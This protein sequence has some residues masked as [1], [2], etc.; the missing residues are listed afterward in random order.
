MK[1]LRPEYE[2]GAQMKDEPRHSFVSIDG[3][4]LHWAELGDASD[5]VPVV[6]LHGILDSHLTWKP[7]GSALATDRRVLTPDLLGCGLSERPDASYALGWHAHVIARWLEILGLARVDVVGHSYG[8]G[9]HRCC[10][11]SAPPGSDGWSWSPLGGSAAP[12]GSGCA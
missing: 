5:T 10:C 12:S 3:M 7:V 9:S 1:P 11:S 2:V 8:G 6:L 4:R